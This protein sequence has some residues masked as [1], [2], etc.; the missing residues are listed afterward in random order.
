MAIYDY[1][2]NEII[3]EDVTDLVK[4]FRGKNVIWLGDSLIDY[5]KPEGY[6]VAYWFQKDTQANCYNW[7]QGG[8]SL[9][10]I[11]NADYDAFNASAMAV[12]LTTGDFTD[13]DAHAEI[14]GFADRV[15]QMK[16]FDFS[17]AQYIIVEYGTNDVWKGCTLDNADDLYDTSTS[18]GSL[19]TMY[20]TLLEYN[21]K[22]KII[23]IGLQPWDAVNG[24]TGIKEYEVSKALND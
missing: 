22:L 4:K 11:G 10:T 2:G 14:R 15:A 18:L 6:T 19:R 16:N 8:T 9:A 21:P 7:C 3:H 23:Q 13:M 1:T 5:E 17:T 12:A 24:N 20:R